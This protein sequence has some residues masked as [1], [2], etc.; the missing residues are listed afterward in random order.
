MK[1]FLA[2]LLIVM[3]LPLYAAPQE[4][5][6]TGVVR[7]VSIIR[8]IASPEEYDGKHVNVVGFLKVEF[9][10]NAIYL[11]RE[12]YVKAL[13]ENAIQLD[14]PDSKVFLK[15]D[16]QYVLVEGTFVRC[17]DAR[18]VCTFSGHIEKIGRLEPW[19][20]QRE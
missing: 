19:R 17:D 12:D 7:H 16:R 6:N 4:Q 8:L 1:P 18:F 2:A 15:Y 14:M 11:H 13:T 20:F 9:E 10:G 3:I 5:T